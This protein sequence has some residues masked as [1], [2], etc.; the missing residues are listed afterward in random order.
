MAAINQDVEELASVFQEL[1]KILESKHTHL[2][3]QL[4]RFHEE[5]KRQQETI[6]ILRKDLELSQ[7]QSRQEIEWYKQESKKCQ[8]KI[9]EYENFYKQLESNLAQQLEA[10]KKREIELNE[11][12]K[13]LQMLNEELTLKKKKNDET[14]L[15][16]DEQKRSI[17][18]RSSSVD[19]RRMLPKKPQYGVIHP[20]SITHDTIQQQFIEYYTKHK[21]QYG[22]QLNKY[23]K[24]NATT[25][26][27]IIQIAFDK[28]MKKII[29]VVQQTIEKKQTDHE[30][31]KAISLLRKSRV[32]LSYEADILEIKRFF[33]LPI[34]AKEYTGSP[35]G[36]EEKKYAYFILLN[37]SDIKKHAICTSLEK[38]VTNELLEMFTKIDHMI[39]DMVKKAVH[40]SWD[41][42]TLVPPAI[43]AQPDKYHDEWQ[44]KRYSYWKEENMDQAL[45]YYRPV[46][47]FSTL[48][49]V[50]C[51][52]KVGNMLPK[53]LAGDS[54]QL[55]PE[56]QPL[57]R[58]EH[59]KPHK[60]CVGKLGKHYGIRNPN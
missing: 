38:E 6:S 44:E 60:P 56:T 33:S 13:R 36:W 12:E 31:I 49:H 22:S 57:N 4:Y 46:L 52:G 59:L 11:K 17:R 54:V 40:L 19:G 21:R 58:P 23:G 28:S 47:F 25:L 7:S 15:P 39:V 48:G 20:G 26:C 34:Y 2:L 45:N 51:K 27:H 10:I 9:Q 8:K 24:Q 14:R 50:A 29:E 1:Q 41:M 43:V 30:V 5:R 55:I 37:S 53:E 42:V 16:P 18:R 32:T 3:Q 35:E